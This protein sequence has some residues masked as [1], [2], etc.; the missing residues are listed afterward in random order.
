MCRADGQILMIY[1]LKVV[2]ESGSAV[3]KYV[4]L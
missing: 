2:A 4:I 1:M 3:T